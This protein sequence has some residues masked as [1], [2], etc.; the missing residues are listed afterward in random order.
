MIRTLIASALVFT[1]ARPAYAACG[2]NH[3]DAEETC[4]DGNTDVGDGCGADCLTEP[5]WE[6]VVTEFLLDHTE[7]L[8]DDGPHSAPDWV[9]SED[10]R[11]I[12][13]SINS[14]ATVYA[15]TLPM[16]GITVTFTL[17]VESGSDDDFIGWAFGFEEGELTSKT[18]DWWVFDWKQVDQSY[19]SWGQSYD[20]LALSH[21]VGATSA[22]DLW[23]HTGTVSEYARAATIGST[24][25]V[26]YQTYTIEMTYNLGT[27]QV[28]VDGVLEFDLAGT[29][30]ESN[31]SFYAFSQQSVSYTL[32]EPSA[33]TV[34]LALDTDSDGLTDPDE[35]ARGTAV[36]NPDTDGDGYGDGDEVAAGTDPLDPHDPDGPVDTGTTDTATT[37]SGT[38]DSG[39]TDTDDTPGDTAGGDDTGDGEAPAGS[40]GCN[41]PKA[42][43]FLPFLA[44][45]RRG[46]RRYGAAASPAARTTSCSSARNQV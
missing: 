8:P 41:D 17:T 20:G 44:F 7:S 30:P 6:C 4:D 21:V 35:Y 23:S 18:A 25:W 24:G 39:T 9:L 34:C 12:E 46:R 33:A 32:V 26:D 29:F 37:D 16:I 13:Q 15:S 11:T 10:G 40:C 42:L 14:Y 36:D 19:G 45:L 38:T 1:V 22:A 31:F 3:L 27:I 2:D 5:G 28:W 43:L